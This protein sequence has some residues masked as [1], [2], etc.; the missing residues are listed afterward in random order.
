M[1]ANSSSAL[2][3]NYGNPELEFERGKGSYLFTSSGEK[4]LDFTMGIA[5]N[6]LG[7]C[8]PAL[9]DALTAQANKLWHT[10]NL[11]RIGQGEKLAR[12]LTELCFAEKVFFCN[13]GSEAIE[14]G[15]KMIRRHFFL[16]GQANK[17]RIISMEQS[18][19]GRTL[20]A[21]SAA[22]NPLHTEG[23]LLDSDAGFDQAVLGDVESLKAA[24]SENTAAVIIEPV[25]GEGGITVATKEYLNAAR[26]LCDKHG[27]LL[28]FDEVQCGVGRTGSFYAHQ[29]MGVEPDI[30]ASAKG[31]GGGFPIAACLAKEFVASSL[32]LG[33]HG[34][35][36]GGNPLGMSVGNAVVGELT[37]EGFLQRVVASGE[38]FREQL[39]QIQVKYPEHIDRI[40]GLGLMIG[41]YCKTDAAELLTKLKA[42]KLLLVKAGANSVR[43]L[44]ALNVSYE[45]IDSALSIMDQVLSQ[46]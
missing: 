26:E 23:F 11:F 34:S 15:F 28:M 18:F 6:S 7:H 45:E 40:S 35:T 3:E 37:R 44:P 5:V 1:S 29:Q 20:A 33:S 41:V 39:E 21:I 19:H 42:E 12:K 46:L 36:F 22:K 30:M 2:T 24:I 43:I 8:H 9:V 10:S 16:K 17:N 27:I 32:T 13:S 38:Y 14:C 31:L 25:Q 4:Y